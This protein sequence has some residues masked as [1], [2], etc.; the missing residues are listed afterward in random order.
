MR[1]SRSGYKASRRKAIGIGI[2]E[3]HSS[4]SCANPPGTRGVV[5]M[6]GGLVG[7]GA[8]LR[9]R[10]LLVAEL[11]ARRLARIVRP[12]AV[13]TRMAVVSWGRCCGM[14]IVPGRRATF[15]KAG[16]QH[17]RVHDA[18]GQREQPCQQQLGCQSAESMT[19]AEH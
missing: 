18:C 3:R 7:P 17:A 1:S 5:P 19:L 12:I 9:A 10:G 15:T 4:W 13:I 6:D 2:A 14:P 16:F 8:S 11:D